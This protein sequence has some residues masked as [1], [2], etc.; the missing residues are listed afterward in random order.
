MADNAKT[1]RGLLLLLL[2]CEENIRRAESTDR[3]T[4]QTA[5][6]TDT[7]SHDVRDL[8]LPLPPFLPSSPLLASAH[9]LTPSLT[10]SLY[11]TLAFSARG[12]VI[13]TATAAAVFE[14]GR[15]R[16]EER[17]QSTFCCTHYFFR[18]SLPPT[19]LPNR[20]MQRRK[21]GQRCWQHVR[22][23]YQRKG[24]KEGRPYSEP[25]QRGQRKPPHPPPPPP[26]PP[27][28]SPYT[29]RRPRIINAAKRG[30]VDD[31]GTD[32]SMEQLPSFLPSSV[33]YF[34]L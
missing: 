21:D 20:I 15:R 12:H 7:H 5:T 6:L 11:S 27:S 24:R 30:E 10:H 29:N 19:H 34:E 32:G 26:P 25:E 23:P 13:I 9:L 17:S 31:G 28:T 22:P 16:G 18:P 14:R 33:P 2:P 4:D 3:P 1:K 8:S